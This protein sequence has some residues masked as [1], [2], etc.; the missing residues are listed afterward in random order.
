MSRRI[1][2]AIYVG[3]IAACTTVADP[4]PTRSQTIL[5]LSSPALQSIPNRPASGAGIFVVVPGLQYG[6]DGIH[7]LEGRQNSAWQFCQLDWP[8]D[9]RCTLYNYEPYGRYGYR[10]LGTYRSQRVTPIQIYVPSAK[11]V[12]VGD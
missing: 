7:L 4:Q 8:R 6:E 3:A 5:E 11:I 12:P 1:A 2:H 9:G 10:P